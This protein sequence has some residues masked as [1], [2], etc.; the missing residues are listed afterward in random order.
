[1]KKKAEVEAKKEAVD[2]SK[3]I[4]DDLTEQKAN[5]QAALDSKLNMRKN[6]IIIWLKKLMI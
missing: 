2:A 6:Y 4:V 3:E 5:Q 1:M